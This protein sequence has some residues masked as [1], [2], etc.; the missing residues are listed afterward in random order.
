M[1]VEKEVLM[2]LLKEETLKARMRVVVK[3]E[4][5]ELD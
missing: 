3:A 5:M 2:E 1:V 4:T